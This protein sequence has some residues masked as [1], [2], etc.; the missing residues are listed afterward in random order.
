VRKVASP[1]E[2]QTEIRK[3]LAYCTEASRPSREVIAAELRGLASRL[4]VGTEG[5][6]GK[7]YE[8]LFNE[9]AKAHMKAH[10]SFG[11]A[12]RAPQ[13]TN[14]ISVILSPYTK[15]LAEVVSL[16]KALHDKSYS[17]LEEYKD[18]APKIK[19]AI[20]DLSDDIESLKEMGKKKIVVNTDTA[21]KYTDLV[22]RT[23]D[24]QKH[25]ESLLNKA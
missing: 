15:A 1:Q 12:L 21:R 11:A 19:E 17:K 18:L 10:A 24:S 9:S 16:A 25:L 20:S 14:Y 7:D 5:L 4:V 22:R 2:L 13:K 8:D 6:T 3:I 23:N